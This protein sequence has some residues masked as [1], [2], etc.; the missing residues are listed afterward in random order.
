MGCLWGLWRAVWGVGGSLGVIWGLGA[1]IYGLGGGSMGAGGVCE[2][3]YGV[4]G[5]HVGPLEVY[6]GSGCGHTESRPLS[7]RSFH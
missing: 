5:L 3:P 7:G 4:W 6:G 1:S 2:A